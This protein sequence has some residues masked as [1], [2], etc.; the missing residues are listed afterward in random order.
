MKNVFS[1]NGNQKRARVAIIISDKTD[2][3]V[4]TVKRNKNWPF[5]EELET[6]QL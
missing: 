1:P 6:E 5:C 3:K 2:H 4:K